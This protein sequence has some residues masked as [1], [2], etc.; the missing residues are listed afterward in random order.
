VTSTNDPAIQQS[1]QALQGLN[2]DDQLGLFWFIYKEMGSSIT[3]AAPGASTVSPDI[4]EGL[5][6][7]VKELS[8]E[9]QLQVQRDLI[10][11]ADSVYTRE[12]G[13][14]GDTTKLLF[15][16]RL[17]QGMDSA[18]IIPVPPGYEL[19]SQARELLDKVKGLG[20]QQQITLFRDY[21][22]PMGAEAKGGAEV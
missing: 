12:Y 20:F 14:M 6:N 7:Q 5:F 2:V 17:A 10:N 1:V 3:P 11:K 19:S 4:A 13:S 9:E 22:S 21:V 15:W 8:H 18:T 16:Y